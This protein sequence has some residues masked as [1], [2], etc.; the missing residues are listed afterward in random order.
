M[1]KTCELRTQWHIWVEDSAN[2]HVYH[3]ETWLLRLRFTTNRHP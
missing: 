1:L 2:K 3:A